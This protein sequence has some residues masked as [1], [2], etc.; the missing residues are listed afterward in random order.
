MISH[1]D[2]GI[3]QI[4]YNYLNLPN[5]LKFNQTYIPRV[6]SRPVNIRS[7]YQYNA[8]GEKLRKIYLHKNPFGS[9]EESV[10][11]DYLDGFQYE[12]K[13]VSGSTAMVALKFVPTAEGYYNFENNKYIYNYTDHLGNVRLS[14]FK[15]GSGAEVL[16]E[17]NYYPFG[18]KH[19]DYNVLPGNPAYTYSYNG[20]ELQTE[21]GMYDY[22]ARFYM[23]DI[24]RWGTI[25]P[26]SQYTHEAYSY[27][28]NNPI[29]F[30]DPTG[31]Q[32]EEISD[33]I[34]NGKGGYKW[35]PN[36]TGPE[37]TPN[38]WKYIG[39]TGSYR[40]PGATVQL[41][42]GGKK[43]TD[44]DEVVVS[45][46]SPAAAG[47]V[48]SQNARFGLFAFLAV[49]SW[50]V[51]SDFV[52]TTPTQYGTRIDPMTH[53]PHTM[54]AESEAASEAESDSTDVNGQEVPQARKGGGK[55]GQ[56]ANQKAKQSAGEKYEEA[57][58]KHDSLR[59]KPNKTKEEA[60]L[61]EKLKK[62]VEHWKRKA[63]ETGENHSRNAK[64]N[65]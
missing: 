60:K 63:D 41:L 42:E 32:G 46:V 9:G 56:H 40:I 19:E 29:T 59:S 33:W 48:L 31:M 51:I 5:F 44:I 30:A 1:Q 21:S 47:I 43:F 12:S 3:L 22:G 45:G 26:R 10:T 57:K 2:K 8:S 4:Q 35:D 50:Y 54:N 55:N 20:K 36:V 62:Q 13:Q 49:A 58:A 14:Y 11:T 18:M 7:F 23:P 61:V 24:G 39:P 64:G 27:V 28:W 6:T 37:N 34:T 15:N 25:D 16:E 38:G 52:D 53:S 65:R 17:N